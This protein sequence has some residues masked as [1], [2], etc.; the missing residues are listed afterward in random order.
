[1]VTRN[2]IVEEARSWIGTPWQH[3]AMVKGHGVDCAML[4]AGICLNTGLITEDDLNMI[5]P[6]PKDW[7][8]HN[9]ESMLIPILE[10]FPVHEIP[11]EEATTADIIMFKVANCESHLGL[12]TDDGWFIHAFSS[13]KVNKVLESRLD[14]RWARRLTRAYRFDEFYENT[15]RTDITETLEFTFDE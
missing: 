2:E 8:F 15:I 7:H 6:Y 11:I 4:I 5:P 12:K 14:D 9:K 10:L 1:M 13:T 3:Q